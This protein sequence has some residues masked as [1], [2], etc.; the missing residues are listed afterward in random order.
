MGIL[1]ILVLALLDVYASISVFLHTTLG[2]PPG[3]ACRFNPTCSDYTRQ[4]VRKNGAFKG[5]WLGLKQ[6]SRCHPWSA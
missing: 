3:Q 5:I 2:V 1:Q 6:L 4:M